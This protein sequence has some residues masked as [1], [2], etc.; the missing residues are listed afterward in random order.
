M[1]SVRLDAEMEKRLAALS[2]KTGR[3]ISYYAREA[4]AHFLDEME[5]AYLA[6]RV[7][8]RNGRRFSQEEVEKEFGLYDKSDE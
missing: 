2:R 8:M 5:E 7:I 4:I 6:E 1:L 3:S